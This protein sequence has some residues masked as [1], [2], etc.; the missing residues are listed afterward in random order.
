MTGGTGLGD[1]DGQGRRDRAGGTVKGRIGEEGRGAV[2][3]DGRASHWLKNFQCMVELF[4]LL[5]Y[6]KGVRT[7]K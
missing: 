6:L 2:T 7:K 1:G 5:R 4:C 3:G